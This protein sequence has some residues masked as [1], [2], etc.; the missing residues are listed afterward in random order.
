M[1]SVA[2]DPFPKSYNF[3]FFR[4]RYKTERIYARSLSY[5]GG[6]NCITIYLC[7]ERSFVYTIIQANI[8]SLLFESQLFNISTCTFYLSAFFGASSVY[9]FLI[10]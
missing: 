4:R 8:D 1:Q 7:A 9:L 6:P 3:I 5:T 10:R 2:F